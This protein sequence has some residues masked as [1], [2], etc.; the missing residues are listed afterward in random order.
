M[1]FAT[2]ARRCVAVSGEHPFDLDLGVDAPEAVR[3]MYCDAISYLPDDIL[4][5]V[6]RASMAVSLE[7]RVPF[8]DHRVAEL[9]ARI[10][11]GLKI[12]DGEGKKHHS[13]DPL[14]PYPARADR[15]AEDRLLSS[16]RRVDQRVRCGIGRR[17]C[18]RARAGWPGR[19]VRP[20]R[21]ASPVAGPSERRR[22]SPQALWA[23]LMF[24]S[25][26]RN[27]K[28]ALAAAA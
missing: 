5:K 27:Q 17:T 1:E 11:L 20:E 18:S 7:T 16:G 14:S 24:Q 15:A 9:A 10:P 25:W 3:I 8:L 13:A 12:R 22:S 28:E 21:R 23:L 26:L 6:D 2:R 19:L 4:C